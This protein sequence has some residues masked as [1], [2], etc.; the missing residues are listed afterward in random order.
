MLLTGKVALI[1]GSSRGIGRSIAE[2]FAA[3]GAI[4]Y[5]NA[6]QTG[7]LDVFSLEMRKAY[8]AEVIPLY[9]DVTDDK[10]SKEAVMRIKK[11]QGRLDVLVNNAGIMKDALIGM[12]TR[13]MIESIFDINVFGLMSMLQLVTKL[14]TRQKSGS[15]IN[16]SSIVGTNGNSGQLVYSASK[17]AVIALTKSAA[18]ELASYNIR[19]NAVAPGIIDTDMFRSIDEKHQTERIE[20]IGMQRVGT[21]KDVAKACVFLASDLSE[22][23][24][25]QILGVDGAAL[26]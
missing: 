23:I 20:K 10:A 1:T 14:M 3:N 6:R 25:G 18:K 22:Y 24:T 15:I 16:M 19:V 9:F 12:I 5:C 17:G 13:E 8:R 21:P 4:V 26:I 7:C 11:E 2:E